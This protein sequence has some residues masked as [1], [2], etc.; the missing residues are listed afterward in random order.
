M[1]LRICS[2]ALILLSPS[3]PGRRQA[4]LQTLWQ[5]TP[6]SGALMAAIRPRAVLRPVG[7]SPPE[8]VFMGIEQIG[9]QGAEAAGLMVE[10]RS[11]EDRL[12]LCNSV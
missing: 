11:G 8:T 1:G 9:E 4:G 7:S 6:H 5:E 10:V 12:R 3:E 2:R